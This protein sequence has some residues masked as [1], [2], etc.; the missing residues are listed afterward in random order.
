MNCEKCGKDIPEQINYC[1]S[2]KVSEMKKTDENKDANQLESKKLVNTAM[3]LIIRLVVFVILL[4]P[5]YFIGAIAASFFRGCTDDWSCGVGNAGFGMIF[6][7]F[8]SLG[9]TFLFSKKARNENN[10]KGNHP[11]KK[12]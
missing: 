7:P 11:M 1:P 3:H 5:C 9:I 4:V 2:C 12:S 6:A 10:R 8:L